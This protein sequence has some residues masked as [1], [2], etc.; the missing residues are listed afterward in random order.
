[1]DEELVDEQW[2][3]IAPPLPQHKRRGRPRDLTAGQLS[4]AQSLYDDPKN[5]ISEICRT[6][7]I[8]KATLYRALKTGERDR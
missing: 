7:K 5:S 4:I 8:S 1:M 2:E 3:L 6:L